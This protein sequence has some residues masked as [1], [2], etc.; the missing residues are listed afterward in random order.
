MS[1]TGKMHRLSSLQEGG[2]LVISAGSF[3]DGAVSSGAMLQE[4]ISTGSV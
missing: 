1:N 3:G 4:S 2:E